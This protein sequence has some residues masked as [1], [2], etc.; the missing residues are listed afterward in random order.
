M[1][2]GSRLPF[3]TMVVAAVLAVPAP[4]TGQ[5]APRVVAA[6]RTQVFGTGQ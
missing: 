2:L 1:R 6:E 4:V 5:A 3:F